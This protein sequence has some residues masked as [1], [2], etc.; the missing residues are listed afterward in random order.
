MNTRGFSYTPFGPALDGPSIPSSDSDSSSSYKLSISSSPPLSSSTLL[1]LLS[2]IKITPLSTS[3]CINVSP[4]K[5][6]SPLTSSLNIGTSSITPTIKTKMEDDCYS[7]ST[8]TTICNLNSSHTSPPSTPQQQ[9]QQQANLNHH[10]NQF[11]FQSENIQSH[12]HLNQQQ[13]H[14][15]HQQNHHQQQQQQQQQSRNNHRQFTDVLHDSLHQNHQQPQQPLQQQQHLQHHQT[16]LSH[17]SNSVNINNIQRSSSFAKSTPLTWT[18]YTNDQITCV[19]EALLHSKEFKKLENFLWTIPETPQISRNETVLRARAHVAFYS[20]NYK[21]LFQIIES[22]SFD[23][24]YHDELSNLWFKAHYMET[25]KTRKRPLCP[26]DKYRA[27]KKHPLPYTIWDGEERIYCFKEKSRCMLKECYNND[28]YP[29]P[30]D[31]KNI[32]EATGL[33]IVQVSNW[34]KNRRQ[35]DQTKK[36]AKMIAAHSASKTIHDYSESFL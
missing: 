14:Q 7:S 31:K 20:A 24:K 13:Q 9:Q 33:T 32:A 11:R 26:V 17:H 28:P 4:C 36:E 29:K 25:E 19:C 22:Y 27:R 3:S 2:S 1:P 8:E 18:S 5:L 35:R 12:H 21:E 6:S 30:E 15:Q 16:Q 34:F 23:P 10:S